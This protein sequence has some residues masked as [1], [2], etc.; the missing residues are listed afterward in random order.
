[1]KKTII[2]LHGKQSTPEGS[3]SGKA[4]REHFSNK[5]NALIPDYKPMERT[6]EE[7]E[8]YLKECISTS[9]KN[10]PTNVGFFCALIP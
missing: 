5:Y 1:M 9:N 7:I 10:K 8:A 2:F 3:G 4:I 6:H